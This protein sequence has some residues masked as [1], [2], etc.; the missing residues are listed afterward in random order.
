[1][2]KKWLKLKSIQ[3]IQVFLGFANFY[4]QFIQGFNRIMAPLIWMLK[5]LLLPERLIFDK[6]E[7]GDGEDGVNVSGDNV[8]LANKSRKLK[9]QKLAKFQKLFKSRKWKDEKLKKPSKSKNLPNFNIIKAGLS[10]L[11]PDARIS[12]NHLRL[13]FNNTQIFWHFDLECHIWIKINASGYAISGML[14]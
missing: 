13:A 12:F 4:W 10:F 6:L 5:T 8:K 1:M 11:T 2:V 3:D 14:N 9:S 7:V